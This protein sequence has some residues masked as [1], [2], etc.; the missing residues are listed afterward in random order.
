MRKY[1]YK[2][3]GEIE[4]YNVTKYLSRYKYEHSF[5]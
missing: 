2:E 3:F 1:F 5:Y 4:Y